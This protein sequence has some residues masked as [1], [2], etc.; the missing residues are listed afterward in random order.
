VLVR[1]RVFVTTVALYTQAVPDPPAG[2]DWQWT[3]PGQYLYDVTGIVGTL[4]TQAGPAGPMVDA[5]GN[6]HDGT[7]EGFGGNTPFVPG[8]V[9]GDLAAQFF[10]SAGSPEWGEIDTAVL[11]FGA[12]W[13]F[14]LVIEPQAPSAAGFLVFEAR[15][16]GYTQ[17]VVLSIGSSGEVALFNRVGSG[18]QWVTGFVFPLDNAPHHLGV[19]YTAAGHVVAIYIDGTATM[20]TDV[21]TTPIPSSP[22][23]TV[24]TFNHVFSFAGQWSSIFD[25]PAFYQ[26]ALSAGAFAA[27][28]AAVGS[29]ASYEAA[30]LADSPTAY[31]HLDDVGTSTGRQVAL[32]ITNQLSLVE[33]V[34]SGFPDFTGPGPYGYSWQPNL[35]SSTQT[36]NGLLTTVAIPQLIL[37]AG[38]TLGTDTLDIQPTDQ[39]SDVT[40]WWNSDVMDAQAQFNPYEYPPGAFLVYQQVK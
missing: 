15:D 25:E 24:T 38:Y 9:P 4:T 32:A 20:V 12:D 19:S 16:V 21:G 37:P 35:N 23:L 11:N 17:D 6:G 26:S 28:A 2:E 5:S 31:Y 13:S 33:L 36:A 10:E 22:A 29:F 7:Y 27:H 1:L 3:V 18:F 40:I 30:V 34:P 39:W 8:L 14:D